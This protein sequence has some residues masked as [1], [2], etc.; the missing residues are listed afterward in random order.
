[1]VLFVFIE[2]KSHWCI[3]T[4]YV[5]DSAP[6]GRSNQVILSSFYLVQS[7]VS[8]VSLSQSTKMQMK[9]SKEN[10]KVKRPQTLAEETA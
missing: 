4:V 5:P 3:F 6:I 2:P 9:K 1:M 8:A 10:R 7:S